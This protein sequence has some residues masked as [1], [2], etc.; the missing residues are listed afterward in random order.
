MRGSAI[1]CTKGG[2]PAA[3]RC[4]DV[5]SYLNNTGKESLSSE[6]RTAVGWL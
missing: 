2:T 3:P 5:L 4:R 1:L 6:R